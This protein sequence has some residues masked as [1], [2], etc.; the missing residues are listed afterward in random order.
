MGAKRT[1]RVRVRIWVA[2]MGCLALM[3]AI[4]AYAFTTIQDD[5]NG[6]AVP[7]RWANASFTWV[8]NNTGTAPSNVDVSDGTN[9]LPIKTVLANAASTWAAASL[10]GQQLTNINITNGADVS[11]L[12]TPQVDCTNVISFN[13]TNTADFPTGTIALAVV[14]QDYERTASPDS[15]GL[16]YTYI[17]C[18]NQT[19]TTTS[20][21]IIYDAD[22]IFNP[23]SSF[24]TSTPAL[25]NSYDL[26]SIATREIG[27]ALGLDESAISHTVMFSGGENQQRTLASDDVIAIGYLY[28]SSSF[29]SYLGT[30]SGQITLA[31]IG[32][33]YAAHVVAIDAVTGNAITDRLTNSDGSYN[34]YVP[35][36][37][38]YVLALP[39]G[40][41]STH[42]ISYIGDFSG[43]SCGYDMSAPPCCD[44]SA[45]ECNGATLFP[46][47]NFTGQFF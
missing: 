29:S 36:G 37:N 38:Y 46:A 5:V 27:Y 33:A 20:P 47:T 26:P 34:L 24:S 11:T 17:E 40:S 1:N 3:G 45:T 19:V 25:S 39:L 28:P 15:P 2:G 30:L 42:G 8:L 41:D 14:S 16:T 7:S 43:W 10:N 18:G 35:P 32:G 44:T 22:I 6:I 4:L 9:P 23:N 21:S 13:D 31:N 12:A